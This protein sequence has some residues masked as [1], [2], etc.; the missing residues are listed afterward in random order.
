MNEIKVVKFGG[1]VK[2]V[3]YENGE[4]VLDVLAHA[5]I[6]LEKSTEVRFNGK[7]VELNSQIT[8]NGTLIVSERVRGGI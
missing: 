7:T 8:Q 4:T 3:I 5:G 1:D 6:N 2:T